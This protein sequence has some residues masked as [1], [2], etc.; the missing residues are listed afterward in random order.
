MLV[1]KEKAVKEAE[2]M[3]GNEMLSSIS[4]Y[5]SEQSDTVLLTT[6]SLIKMCSA[7][8]V[9]MGAI[10]LPFAL[11]VFVIKTSK[12]KKA[13]DEKIISTLKTSRRMTLIIIISSIALI[14]AGVFISVCVTPMSFNP[15]S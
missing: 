2:K 7:I 13:E 3:N 11:I 9:S 5:I 15:T 8:L 12:I 6:G 1:D 10:V 4:S 14:A